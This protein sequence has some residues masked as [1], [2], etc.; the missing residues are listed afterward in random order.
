M[1]EP[2]T[3]TPGAEVEKEMASIV[4]DYAKS[5]DKYKEWV[6]WAQERF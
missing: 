6:N 5:A 3:Y 2:A 4:K 1:G